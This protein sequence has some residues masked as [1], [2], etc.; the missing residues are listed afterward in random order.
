[1]LQPPVPAQPIAPPIANIPPQPSRPPLPPQPLYGAPMVI[2]QQPT[3][4]SFA[5]PPPLSP[6]PPLAQVHVPV[7]QAPAWVVTPDEKIKYDALFAKTDAD[8]DGFVSGH[9]IKDVFLQSGVSQK[10]LAHIWW[11]D[12]HLRMTK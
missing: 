1:M 12:C 8:R 11:V 6:A 9:E 10:V 5:T 2:T 4:N 7:A 3:V